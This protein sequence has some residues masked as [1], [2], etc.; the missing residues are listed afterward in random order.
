MYDECCHEDYAV[1]LGDKHN[2]TPSI[3]KDPFV[4]LTELT[5]V[6]SSSPDFV[7]GKSLYFDKGVVMNEYGDTPSVLRGRKFKNIEELYSALP[8]GTTL[9]MCNNHVSEYVHGVGCAKSPKELLVK[10]RADVVHFDTGAIRETK[11]NKGRFDLLPACAI[12]RVAKHY[13]TGAINHGERNW[14][15]GLPLHSYL[16]SASRHINA[17]LDGD[18]SED[19]L[20]AIVWNIFG[21]MWNEEKLPDL[22]DIPVRQGL[23]MK[24]INNKLESATNE[25]NSA[26]KF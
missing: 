24:F 8:L 14:E 19:H 10:D 13:E 5:V 17:Y 12:L 22:C 9:R 7:L 16:D 20:S 15:K 3:V 21:A 25:S 18:N 6:S 4:R 11:K 23:P 1:D 2:H 26:Q